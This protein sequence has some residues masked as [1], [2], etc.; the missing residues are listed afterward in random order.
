ML[1]DMLPT[2]FSRPEV[3]ALIDACGLVPECLIT[4][5]L[6]DRIQCQLNLRRA[7]GVMT[8]EQERQAHEFLSVVMERNRRSGKIIPDPFDFAEQGRFEFINFD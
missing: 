2:F 6:I 5:D 1:F 8:A 3:I 4:K 7:S